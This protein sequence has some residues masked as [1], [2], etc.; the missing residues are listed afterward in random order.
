MISPKQ[1]GYIEAVQRHQSTERREHLPLGGSG[2]PHGREERSQQKCVELLLPRLTCACCPWPEHFLLLLLI[3]IFSLKSSPLAVS[4]K[5]QP[6]W[7]PDPHL[8]SKS[9]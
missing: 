7:V 5:T 1:G 2:T 8:G 4:L 9:F 6:K 3:A